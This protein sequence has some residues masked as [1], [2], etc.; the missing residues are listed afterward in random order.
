MGLKNDR[1]ILHAGQ[2]LIECVKIPKVGKPLAIGPV[3]VRFL[4]EGRINQNTD[5]VDLH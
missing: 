2:E 3:L 1:I 4:V 5:W